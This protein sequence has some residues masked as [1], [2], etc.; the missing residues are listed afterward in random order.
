M[1]PTV[2]LRSAL[3]S[4]VLLAA[5][6]SEDVARDEAP[7]RSPDAS[8]A[9]TERAF[10]GHRVWRFEHESHGELPVSWRVGAT[11]PAAELA[12]WST[13]GSPAR[14]G[15]Q[16][17]ALTDPRGATGQTYNLCWTDE[18]RFLNGS[19]EVAVHAGA[20]EED[21]GGGPA[22]RIRGPNDYYLARWNPLEENFRV[23]SVAGGKR[24]TLDSA[25]VRADPSAW[26]T[27]SVRH[28]GTL[29]VCSFDEQELLHAT[30]AT[31]QAPGGVGLWTKADAATAFDDLAATSR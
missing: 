8:P 21:Q 19:V 6:A 5:C 2:P 29:I 23:Y 12:V 27:I 1:R 3:L 14:S 22:W 18:I 4:S 15:Q 9:A 7:P 26:H 24:T 30:D 25:E 31:H 16:A 28:E 20:G 11:N 10:T 17:L 13:V